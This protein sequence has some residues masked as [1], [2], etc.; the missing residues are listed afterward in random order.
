MQHYQRRVA[1]IG[2]SQ[3]PAR[4]TKK[5]GSSMSKLQ[6]EMS[7]P[8]IH[9]VKITIQIQHFAENYGIKP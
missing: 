9:T 4:N 5:A 6:Q 1:I 2:T 8:V 7:Y 3:Y